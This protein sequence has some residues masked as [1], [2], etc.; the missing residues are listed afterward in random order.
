VAV[1]RK[2]GGRR[3]DIQLGSKGK[4]LDHSDY[5]SCLFS[6]IVCD[7]EVTLSPKLSWLTAGGQTQPRPGVHDSSILTVCWVSIYNLARTI[8]DT[9]YPL[10]CCRPDRIRTAEYPSVDL[11]DLH[12]YCG[13]VTS[14]SASDIRTSFSV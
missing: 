4:L 10:T 14:S 1:R 2:G 12:H 3:D 9:T 6:H 8:L 5:S 13:K 11:L 7:N